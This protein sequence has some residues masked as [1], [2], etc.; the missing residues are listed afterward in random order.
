MDRNGWQAAFRA[1]RS[2]SSVQATPP[3]IKDLHQS[4]WCSRHLSS[5]RLRHS[6]TILWTSEISPL[7][8]PRDRAMNT[9]FSQNLADQT[10][11]L[12]TSCARRHEPNVPPKSPAG[13]TFGLIGREWA[14]DRRRCRYASRWPATTGPC[15]PAWKQLSRPRRARRPAPLHYTFRYT[16]TYPS[17]DGFDLS[18][19]VMYRSKTR[20][21][22]LSQSNFHRE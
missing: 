11:T 7:R 18:E 12:S 13:R 21:E 4:L 6:S 5:R 1:T 2:S 16:K 15:R 10:G 19:P 3:P 17:V 14:H 22:D 20:D 9:G 8:N